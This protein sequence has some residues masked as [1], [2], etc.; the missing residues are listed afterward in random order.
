[1]R[2]EQYAYDVRVL[3]LSTSMRGGAG[4]AA[5]RLHRALELRGVVSAVATRDRGGSS[6]GVF[7]VSPSYAGRFRSFAVGKLNLMATDPTAPAFFSPLETGFDLSGALAET[8]PDVLH[9]HNLYGLTSLSS[10]AALGLPVVATLHDQRLM[11]GGCHYAD[12][13]DSYQQECRG[14]FQAKRPMRNWVSR[15]FEAHRDAVRGISS[16]AVVSPSRWL[17]DVAESSTV[18]GGLRVR[19]IRNCLAVED[20]RQW[21]SQVSASSSGLAAVGWLPG[22]GHDLMLELSR[23][24][25]ERWSTSG[26]RGRQLI[27]HTT[28]DC[29]PEVAAQWPCVKSFGWLNTE[30][31][32]AKFW[33]SCAVGVTTTQV[34]NF[35]NVVLES[36]AA[37]TP[38]VVPDVGGTPEIIR[39]SGA[40]LVSPRTARD[41]A[42]SLEFILSNTSSAAQMSKQGREFAWREISLEA[43]SAKYLAVYE[44]LLSATEPGHS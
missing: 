6:K 44:D 3:H 7:R 16:L 32:R 24:M 41:L 1:M 22:K 37:G 21:G 8:R 34:D 18:L 14:C 43:I 10:I 2:R 39:D 29:P 9:L 27:L 36:V 5:T 35:P 33:G 4:I 40:G 17:K 30:E 28:D 12:S 26:S 20:F 31:D 19:H 15:S 23:E 42:N 38:F 11:S 25:R 13:C